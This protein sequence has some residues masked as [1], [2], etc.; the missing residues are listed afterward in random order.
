[1]AGIR[2]K[3]FSTKSRLRYAASLSHLKKYFYQKKKSATFVLLLFLFYLKGGNLDA[4]S[5]ACISDFVD[6]R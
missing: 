1:M 5:L 2:K 6:K 3:F 4:A